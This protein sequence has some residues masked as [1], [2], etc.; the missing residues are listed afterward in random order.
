[1][2][3]V[4]SSTVNPTVSAKPLIS[5]VRAKANSLFKAGNLTDALAAYEQALS[6]PNELRLPL[7]ANIGLCH[8]RLGAPK[9]AVARL[10]EA[11][12]LAR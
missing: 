4:P 2:A 5:D 11:L 6:G 10:C 3:A 12:T 9:L 1:M 8:I 7:L